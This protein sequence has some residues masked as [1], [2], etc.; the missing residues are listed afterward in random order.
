M[1]KIFSKDLLSNTMS[2]I[3]NIKFTGLCEHQSKNMIHWGHVNYVVLFNVLM[4]QAKHQ[5]H[6]YL[7]LSFSN[8][9]IKV[10]P[11]LKLAS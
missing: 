4:L 2:R 1:D 6:L 5:H 11:Q 3:K 9:D 7:Y 8:N 10:Q